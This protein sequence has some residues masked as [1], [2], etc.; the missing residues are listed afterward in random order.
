MLKRDFTKSNKEYF[1]KNRNFL[2]ALGVF[3]LV[4]I[5]VFAIFGMNG[6]FEIKGYNEF[7]IT[8]NEKTTENYNTHRD[9][10]GEIINSFNGKFD[11]MLIYGEG[12][13]TQYVVRYLND[14]SNKKILEINKLV[15]EE[16]GVDVANVSEH[17]KVG[18]IVKNT[19]YIFTAVSILLLV[20]IS[21]IFAY[22]RYN[23][24]SAMCVI[25][26]SVIGTIGFIS[27]G[28]ILQLSIGMS[29]FALLVILNLMIIYFAIELF[30]SMHKSSWLMS[31][32]FSTAIETGL[33]SS[34]FR[35]TFVAVG[36]LAIGLLLVLFAPLTIKYIA[37]N[38]MFMA[39]VVLA[40]GWYVVPFVWN[41]FITRCIKRTY[42]VKASGFQDKKVN[43]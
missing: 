39:V 35:M 7:S 33:K 31:E 34:K 5:L 21:S 22:V 12:D 29:Y 24:A 9:E 36:L 20:V 2:I 42:K 17:V 19:D 27:I 10:I 8:V 37:I 15:A 40:V 30:E 43:K 14:V 1:K 3:L 4:G 13:D 16:V 23:G 18:G 28:S 38:I 6:N 41:V 25:I 32:D 26:A 11:N